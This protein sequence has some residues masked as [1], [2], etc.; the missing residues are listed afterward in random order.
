MRLEKP[1]Q[2]CYACRYYVGVDEGYYATKITCSNR[3]FGDRQTHE[4]CFHCGLKFSDE[5]KLKWDD[6]CP[7]CFTSAAYYSTVFNIPPNT[8]T[9][10]SCKE[11]EEPEPTLVALRDAIRELQNEVHKLYVSVKEG[12]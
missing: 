3:R 7:R 5:H 8:K 9:N 4:S 10:P 11:F 1:E 12:E 6:R 2:T